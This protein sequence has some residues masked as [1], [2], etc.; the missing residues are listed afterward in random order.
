MD[1]TVVAIKNNAKTFNDATMSVNNDVSIGYVYVMT[2]SLF[3]DVV[4]IGC[5]P[6]NPEHYTKL[7]SSKTIGEYRL[8]YSLQCKNPCKIK[9]QIK[10]YLNAKKYVS[11]FYQVSTEIAAKLLQ[12]ETLK[13]PVLNNP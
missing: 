4:R 5:T 1:N 10:D 11:E 9:R 13:I 2:H 6:E 3:S 7:L 8:A 12:R